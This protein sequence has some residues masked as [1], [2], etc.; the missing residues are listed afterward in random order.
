MSKRKKIAV[1]SQSDTKVNDVR[2][3]MNGRTIMK[4]I[5]DLLFITVYLLAGLESSAS[6]LCCERNHVL[7]H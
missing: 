3:N 6:W 2:T 1:H 7:H 4:E 5:D